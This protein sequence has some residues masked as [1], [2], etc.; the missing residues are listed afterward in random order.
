MMITPVLY[1]I[2]FGWGLGSS[3]VINGMSYISFVIP[4]IIAMSSMSTSFG[5]VANNI[6]IARTYDKT[7]E[8]FMTAPINMRSYAIGKILASALRGMYAAA[9]IVILCLIFRADL[10]MNAYSAGIIMLNCLVFSALGFMI[11]IIIE[12]HAD[13]GKFQN[14]VIAPMSFLCGTFFPL[15]NMPIILKQFIWILPLT[16]TSIALRRDG[17]M[18]I[19]PWLHPLI[20]AVY[21]LMLFIIGVRLCKK[22]E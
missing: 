20:L 4:G 22:A 6:N 17:E 9:L 12:S 10:H 8:E 7:F 1:L 19:N 2:A 3:T 21:F 11:G 18:F 16:Q 15:A 14:F 5:T 13:M